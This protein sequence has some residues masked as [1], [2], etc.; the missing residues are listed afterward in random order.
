MKNVAGH[1]LLLSG[2]P[3]PGKTTIAEALAHLP[4]VGKYTFIPMTSGVSS[5]LS[6]VACWSLAP[7]TWTLC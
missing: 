7:D 2:H 1:I 6:V 5:K 3:G 4:G